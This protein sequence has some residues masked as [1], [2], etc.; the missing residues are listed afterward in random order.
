MKILH[1]ITGLG[2]GGAEHTLYKICKYDS[3]NNHI[4]ISLSNRGKYFSLLKKLGIEVYNLNINFF[5][6]YKFFYLVK[7]IGT[8]K[9]DIVQTWLVHADFLGSIAARLAG[10]KNI[11]WNIR[12][13]KIQF[14]K[15]K[16][17]TILILKILAKLSYFIP[18]LII[19]VSKKAKKIYKNEGYDNKK[20]LFIPNGY[21]LLNLKPNSFETSNLLDK[22]KIKNRTPR[23]GYVARY[24][25]LK[26][27]I[28]LLKA[29]SLIRLKKIGF[30]C[31]LVGNNINN[32]ISLNAEIKKLKLTSCVKLMG[33]TKNVSKIMK[34]LDVHVQSSRSEGFPNVIAEAM[35]VKTPCVV[36]NVGDS[37]YIVGNTGWVVP[38]DNSIKLA[39]AIESAIKE[40]RTK[41]WSKRRNRARARIRDKFSIGKMIKSYNKGWFKVYNKNLKNN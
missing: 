11:V 14:G 3:T 27:H 4:V 30:F 41:E 8:L 20:F 2:D 39:I 24:D 34:W 19:I 31:L 33:P 36:T 23:I 25:P 37:S 28:N 32:N 9:P 26:D 6:I 13:S 18:Q 12:Y 29:L 38:A 40:I 22:I 17:T 35:A 5:S 16:F 15:A 7:L 10:F 1:I 21:D